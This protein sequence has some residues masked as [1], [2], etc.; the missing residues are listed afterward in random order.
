MIG[1]AEQGHIAVEWKDTLNSASTFSETPWT[2]DAELRLCRVGATVAVYRRHVGDT[3]WGAP[4]F[5]TSRP[6]LPQTLQVGLNMYASQT[7]PDL[8]ASFDRIT[9]APASSLADCAS[10]TAAGA[11]VPALTWGGSVTATLALAALGMAA[12]RVSSK[13]KHII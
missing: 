3:S 2:P 4:Y 6:D 5:Q 8:D 12:A 1:Y 13:R 7:V 10:D 11:P 9:F